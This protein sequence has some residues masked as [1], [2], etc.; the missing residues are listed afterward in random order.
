M[1]IARYPAQLQAI[2][3]E[4]LGRTQQ[5][6]LEGL[7]EKAAS[8]AAKE[9]AGR[10]YWYA[11]RRVGE[12]VV[13][14]YVGPETPELLGHLDAMR[15][16]AE[17]A[18]AAAHGRRELVRLLRAGGYPVPDVRTGRALQDRKSTRLNSSH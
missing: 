7:V 6:E 10:R 4:L 14:R 15:A 17:D 16:E 5:A 1:T 11:R 8:L 18:K 2:Y 13:E 12:R 9:V 3:S